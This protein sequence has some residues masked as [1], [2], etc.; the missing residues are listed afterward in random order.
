[1][2]AYAH[3]ARDRGPEEAPRVTDPVAALVP[4]EER[5][6]LE[7]VRQLRKWMDE[8]ITVPGTKFK[9]G[10]DGLIGLIPGVGDAA[11]SAIGAYML[12]A[13]NRL[14]VPT[15]VMVRMLFNQLID[16]V[17]G[18]IP[19]F[20]DAFDFLHKANSKNARLVEES[21]VNRGATAAGS[22]VRLTLAMVVF[23]G[24]VVG[25]IV[26]SIFLVRWAMQAS[27]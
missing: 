10:L 8:A 23:F 18:M 17:V 4:R 26:G 9:F 21:I 2:E 16:A 11:S 1:V 13:A 14:G 12:H 3:Q 6:E 27:G 19:V 25:G 5:G 22:W 20:G 24:I 15:I 7:V